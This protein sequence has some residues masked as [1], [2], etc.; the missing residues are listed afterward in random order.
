MVTKVHVLVHSIFANDEQDLNRKQLAA[1]SI[2]RGQHKIS[3]CLV[4]NLVSCKVKPRGLKYTHPK[5]CK[6]KR[7]STFR[8]I[9]LFP[10]TS[11][12][13]VKM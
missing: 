13:K 1:K 6:L 4:F 2:R 8:Q 9:S 12:E 5:I 7:E 3:K 11:K 10:V